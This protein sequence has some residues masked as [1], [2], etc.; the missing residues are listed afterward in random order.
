MTDSEVAIID[1]AILGLAKRYKHDH[2]LTMRVSEV[3]D[4]LLDLRNLLD[5]PEGG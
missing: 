2:H 3:V 5:A 1:K 4:I